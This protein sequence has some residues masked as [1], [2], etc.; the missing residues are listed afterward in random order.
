MML[1]TQRSTP[2]EIRSAARP[3]TALARRARLVAASLALLFLQPL[4][5]SA[6][7]YAEAPPETGPYGGWPALEVAEAPVEVV[8]DPLE[9]SPPD[10]PVDPIETIATDALAIPLGNCSCGVDGL[11]WS[12]GDLGT[13]GWAIHGVTDRGIRKLPDG[14]ALF[15]AQENQYTRYVENGDVLTRKWSPIAEDAPPFLHNGP[16]GIVN[17]QTGANYQETVSGWF[18]PVTNDAGCS[19][20]WD[21]ETHLPSAVFDADGTEVVRFSTT[22][23]GTTITGIDF[24]AD[25]AAQSV[26]L[27]YI[28]DAQGQ[29]QLSQ[30]QTPGG[31]DGEPLVYTLDHGVDTLTLSAP[32]QPPVALSFHP[33]TRILREKSVGDRKT[34]FE[35]F[36]EADQWAVKALGPSGKPALWSGTGTT[37]ETCPLYDYTPT[38]SGAILQRSDGSGPVIEVGVS[39]EGVRVFEV[40]TAEDGSE[41]RRDFDARF[42]LPVRESGP[43]GIFIHSYDS[44]GRH[45]RT[46]REPDGIVLTQNT[47]VGPPGDE[48][49][50]ESVVTDGAGYER[51]SSDNGNGSHSV[52]EQRAE[53]D[54]Y[55]TE[56]QALP[57]G[58]FE[59]A[60][61]SPEG[62]QRWTIAEDGTVLSEEETSV[63]EAIPSLAVILETSLNTTVEVSTASHC[64]TSN[65]SV[66]FGCDGQ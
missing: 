2:L 38:A 26:A 41:H 9:I 25:S 46:L 11:T 35:I 56:V 60:E 43:A 59:Q 42:N 5:S 64:L 34:T 36:R 63:Q 31:E 14:Y 61:G 54:W 44:L 21:F 40:E 53:G 47:W 3:M 13:A 22:S 62:V 18:A 50:A 55:Y 58:G 37:P 19:I 16:N 57:G 29:A 4:T 24:P 33:G 8:D 49:L 39:P 32:S 66:D 52:F 7:E 27:D 30:V 48:Y 17:P 20:A 1:A 51:R 65:G 45:V 15:N 23:S 10:A 6:M 28:Y 12:R